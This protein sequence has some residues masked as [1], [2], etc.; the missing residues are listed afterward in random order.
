MT[1]SAPIERSGHAVSQRVTR[2]VDQRSGVLSSSGSWA[3]MGGPL[4]SAVASRAPGQAAAPSCSRPRCVSDAAWRG[5]CVPHAE[6][7]R[8][9]REDGGDE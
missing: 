7:V 8:D 5:L 4:P 9:E 1:S 2:T 3:L 6:Q